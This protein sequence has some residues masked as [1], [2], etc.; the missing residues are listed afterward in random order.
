M[1]CKSALC[2]KTAP[3]IGEVVYNKRFPLLAW[4]AVS[5]CVLLPATLE[6]SVASRF[7]RIVAKQCDFV[8]LG[9]AQVADI[10]M[11]AIGGAEARLALIN[12][13]CGK[14]GGVEAAHLGLGACLKG[15]HG[16]VA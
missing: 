10:K 16:A 7:G 5:I 6:L 11:R 9:V 4:V 1:F 2:R 12:A 8:A 14:G 13:A 3:Y 15:D